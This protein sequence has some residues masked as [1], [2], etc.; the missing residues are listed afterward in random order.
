MPIRTAVV[1]ST[2]GRTSR[3]RTSTGLTCTCRRTPSR[4]RQRP[5]D[6]RTCLTMKESCSAK[7]NE[8]SV[9]RKWEHIMRAEK[10]TII[11]HVQTWSLVPSS[12]SAEK[13]KCISQKTQ[14]AT[15][16]QCTQGAHST[17]YK[18][19]RHGVCRA[20]PTGRRRQ[21]FRHITASFHPIRYK[22]LRLVM[23]N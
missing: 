5:Q 19:N 9:G 2:F 11:R 23:P 1:C 17:C 13:Q 8:G 12:R 14:D 16:T 3:Q 20:G 18:G 15:G 7:R 21:P 10:V 22:F 6:P 4:L